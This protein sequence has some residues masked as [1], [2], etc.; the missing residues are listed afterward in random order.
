MYGRGTSF[1]LFVLNC[2]ICSK[3]GECC[4]ISDFGF[5]CIYGNLDDSSCDRIS[6]NSGIFIVGL[7]PV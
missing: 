4:S 7:P 6:L 3:V 1:F 2:G 5:G